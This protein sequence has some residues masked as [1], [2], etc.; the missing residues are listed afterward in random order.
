MI[1]TNQTQQQAQI[2]TKKDRK[3]DRK[4][5]TP[6]TENGSNDVEMKEDTDDV[7]QPTSK[8]LPIKQDQKISKEH[9]KMLNAFW[10]LS[11][12]NQ[13]TRLDAV[14]QIAKY[15]T[16]L[17][18]SKDKE[19]CNYVLNRLIRGL[20]SN[21]KCS[22]IGFSCCLTEL[23]NL[24][25]TLH[26]DYLIDLAKSNLKCTNDSTLTKEELRHM[27]IG[28]VFV[29]LCWIQSNRLLTTNEQT[30][31]TII[32][33][34][35]TYRTNAE[36]KTYIQQLYLQALI[37]LIKKLNTNFMHT[38][39]SILDQDLKENWDHSEDTSVQ[40]IKDNLNLLLACLNKNSEVTSEYLKKNNLKLKSIF[41]TKKFDLF[42]DILSQSTES[43][44]N[45]QPI[46]A[47]LVQYLAVNN[48]VYFKQFWSDLVDS[49]LA[50]KRDL[51]KKCLSFKLFLFSLG[52]VNSENYK[53]VFYESLL[54]SV[55]VLK[56]FV[57][58][59]ANKHAN[60]SELVRD[61]IS[62][63]LIEVV[64]QKESEL[65]S[66]E[67]ASLGAD[68]IIKILGYVRNYHEISDLVSPLISVLNKQSLNKLFDFMIND[69]ISND[70]EEF[71]KIDK[72]EQIDYEIQK[73]EL[74]SKETWMLNQITNLAK[75]TSTFGDENL[76]KK[77]LSYV[78]IHSYF[79]VTGAQKN[80][81]IENFQIG[82]GLV[83]NEKMITNFRERLIEYIG[84]IL[85]KNNQ[86]ADSK[87]CSYTVIAELVAS[88]KG[89]IDTQ[90][91]VRLTEK[92]LKKEKDIKEL[93]ARVSKMLNDLVG[94]TTKSNKTLDEANLN[95]FQ[96]F[97]MC[98][99]IEFFRMFDSIKNTKQTLD[100]IE[101]CMQKFND[102]VV[103]INTKPKTNKKKNK[104]KKS[105]DE[106]EEF[107]WI[108]VLVEMLLNLFTINTSWI[109]NAVK[110]QFRKL[111]PKLTVKSVKLIVDLLN[112]EAEEDLLEEDD[113]DMEHDGQE[114]EE[115]T[116]NVP[117]INGDLF[118]TKNN[119]KNEE[120]E[121]GIE[122]LSMSPSSLN[123]KSEIKKKRK[124]VE[125]ESE[126]SEDDD[127]DDDEE[128]EA[129]EGKSGVDEEL[130]NSLLKA[131]GNAVADEKDD[132]GSDLDDDA[133]LK[134]D[135]TIAQAFRLK[136]QDKKRQ[137][138]LI[139][140]KLRVLD[141]IQELFKSTHRLDL[142]TV[143]FIGIFLAFYGNGIF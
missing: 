124:E 140:Y 24:K 102:E 137:N 2:P 114:T 7:K 25:D 36:F 108:D 5:T 98:I 9:G 74:I 138:E 130:K 119:G 97:F 134:L 40:K 99:S 143:I 128:E 18:L 46:C 139:Q 71:S 125:E 90:T 68:L 67:E 59:Y 127:D 120:E 100:D 4:S 129:E 142:I 117:E 126:E 95:V 110:N 23:I 115:D 32:T 1:Q 56:M 16:D 141:L 51:E 38:I 135:E 45:L 29:Y 61:E 41:S 20:G 65:A 84:V 50:S 85:Y 78:S 96:T 37:I 47:E 106:D 101:I 66:V 64:R 92:L 44:P 54:A 13:N 27:Q 91:S 3:K 49:K 42:Y 53:I 70:L 80:K 118:L 17:D 109:R 87:V 104:Q 63:G 15:F 6:A 22:R 35:N 103:N 73:E 81:K 31:K 132:D 33:D 69:F 112:P 14:Q 79:D 26:F 55:N 30:L 10:K 107:E 52:F 105:E 136:S 111:L 121:S 19:N 133:M 122:D 43:L 28:L 11:E 8:K 57:L 88:V 62:K 76:I 21:R 34:L 113:D 12:F 93:S 94:N 82:S 116:E 60:L 123:G 48:S 77:V 72:S 58:S 83:K 39:F 86:S 89:L 131:L 75:N